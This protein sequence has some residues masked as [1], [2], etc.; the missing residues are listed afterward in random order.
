MSAA[1][2]ARKL[3]QLPDGLALVALGAN[4]GAREETL[5][6]A[7]EALDARPDCEL[8]LRSS[9]HVTAP[10]GGPLGQPDFLNGA[11]LLYTQLTPEQLLEV[12]HGIEA[13]HG[14]ERRVANGPRTLDL[15]LLL[16]GTESRSGPGLILPHPRVH[17][18]AFVLAP[19]AE[20]CPALELLGGSV[21]ELLAGLAA[22]SKR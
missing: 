10:V 17:E 5:E 8:A 4:L 9:W 21:A 18:R 16:H 1:S 3:V 6:A 12:L 11:A 22:Q 13:Q 19:V 14:R 15:D 20:L 2:A 7:L